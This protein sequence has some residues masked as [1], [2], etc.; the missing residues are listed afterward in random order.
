MTEIRQTRPRGRPAVPETVQQGRIL[1]AAATILIDQGYA[2]MTMDAVALAAG[3]AKKT[4][5]RFAQDREDLLG[6]IVHGWTDAFLPDFASMATGTAEFRTLLEDILTHIAQRVLTREAVGLFRLLVIDDVPERERILA[7]YDSNGVTRCRAML[8]EWLERHRQA[9]VIELAD[10]AM[11]A[12]LILSMAV[13]EPLRRIAIGLAQPQ[14]KWDIRPRMRAAIDMLRLC[15]A[16][17]T[18]AS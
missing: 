10:S 15:P 8:A 17:A 6:Q 2:A 11:A 12:D 18:D 7:L 9:G 3:M 14:P 1:R 5:Y 16:T 13:A 4:L